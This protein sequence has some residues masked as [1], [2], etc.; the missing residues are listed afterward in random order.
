MLHWS[1]VELVGAAHPAVLAACLAAPTFEPLC[2]VLL[3]WGMALVH[4]GLR[5]PA[6][7]SW[8]RGGHLCP[9][10]QKEQPRGDGCA[11]AAPGCEK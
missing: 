11:G 9:G 1:W 8:C 5:A 7:C 4:P 2:W 10:S 6:S 3:D